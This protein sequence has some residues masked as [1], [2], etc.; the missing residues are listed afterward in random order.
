MGIPLPQNPGLG[1]IDELTTSEEL[2]VQN[3]ASLGD[4]NA[5]RI[6]FWDDSAGSFQYLTVGSGLTIT[7]TTI[8]ASGGTGD[9]SKVGTP[10]NGQVGYWTGDGTLAGDAHF[11][12][13]P[14]TDALHV[15]KIAGDATDGL[16]FESE[17]GTN[18]GIFGVANTANGTWYGNHNYDT[19]TANTIASFGASKTLGSLA[20][21]TYPDLTE[22]SYVKGVTSAIQTQLNGKQASGSYEVTTNKA[23]DFSTLNNTL[24]PT[25]EAVS[26]Y[27]A[28][29][30]VGLLDYRGSYDASTNL[31]PATGGSGTAGAVLKGDFWICSVAGTLGGVAVTAGDL[32][33][34][35]VDTPAQTSTNWD[36]ISNE[37]GYTPAN[38]TLS[39]LGTVAINTT[40]AS[41]TDNTDDLGTTL[42]KW[43]NLFVTTIGATATRVTK[44]WFTDIESTNMPTVGGVA[45]LSSLTAPQFTTI[46]LGHA[47]DTTISRVSAGLIAVEG[48]NLIRASDVDDTPVNGETAV[49]V[50]SNWAFDHAALASSDT[51]VGHIEIATTAETNTGTDATRAVSPD[52]LAGSYAGTKS[53]VIDVI[54]SGT[55]LTTGDN[56]HSIIIPSSLNGMD[57]VAAHARVFTAGTTGTTDI[58]IHNVTDAVDILS[59]KITIDSTETTSYTAATAPAI[60][61]SNDSVATGDILRVDIDA[62]STTAPKGLQVILEFRLP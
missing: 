27:V 31:F 52:G 58:Q 3:L 45:I 42:K 12:F 43:A 13:D 62:I 8:T 56:K 40:L 53:A 11:T 51:V 29:Q 33:I 49:P 22:L 46:E 18:I 23:T 36:L 21:A 32:I 2:L 26:T 54:A 60:N 5:D 35:L 15:H 50:S 16:I 48:S 4:P 44:G 25:T 1:G 17:N 19:A 24:Y 39:N 28:A 34:A 9:V 37:L 57:L 55:D 14:A 41:D 10:V 7:G 6:L 38:D 59:T 20:T 61:T 30:V 47:S